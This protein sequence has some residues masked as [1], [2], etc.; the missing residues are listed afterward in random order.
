[1]GNSESPLGLGC[2]EGLGP[3]VEAGWRYVPSEV[4]G[5]QVLTQDPKTAQLA[6]E[7]GREVQPLYALTPDDVAAVNA[8]RK[9]AA[10][11]ASRRLGLCRCDHI[12][13]CQHCFPVE[14][15]AGGVWGGP[16]VRAK[17]ATTAG[18][19]A[20][21]GENVQRTTGPGLVACRWRSA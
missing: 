20:R 5:D 15:R 13:Y 18:R 10:W 21:A 17:R 8:A 6:R 1:M 3:L 4:W 19:Q 7:Y 14:F 11:K 16:N 2:N 9:E 12:E